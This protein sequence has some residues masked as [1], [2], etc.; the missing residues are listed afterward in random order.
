MSTRHL[1][2]VYGND[3]LTKDEYDDTSD[4]EPITRDGKL[5]NF[6]VFNLVSNI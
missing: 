4:V 6:N 3:V 2:R 1:R 5:K